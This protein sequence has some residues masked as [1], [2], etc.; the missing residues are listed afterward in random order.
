LLPT[1]IALRVI[2]FTKLWNDRLQ[3][4]LRIRLAI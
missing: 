1:R 2:V 3:A 4:V